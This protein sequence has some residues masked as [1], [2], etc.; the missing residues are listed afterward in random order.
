MKYSNIGRMTIFAA[1]AA[2]A[3]LTVGALLIQ[4]QSLTMRITIPFDFYVGDKTLP[5]GTYEVWR[6]G[7]SDAVSITDRNGHSAFVMTSGNARRPGATSE[8]QM[9]FSGYDNRYFLDEIRWSGYPI[10]RSVPKSK[11]Q[12]QLAQAGRD[13]ASLAIATK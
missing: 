7:T 3:T 10:A 6:S 1:V 4:A 9:V 13:P 12:L 11:L 8:S 5:A 2:V